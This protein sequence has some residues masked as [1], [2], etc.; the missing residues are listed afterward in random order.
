MKVLYAAS[1]ARPFVASGGLADV[2]GSLPQS[3]VRKGVDCR[4]VIPLYS[5]ISDELRANI[6]FVME[7]EIYVAW[8][9]R[10][11][12]VYESVYN[13]VTYY[14]IEN[15]YYFARDTL[16]EEFD[17]AERF[18][19]FCRAVLE[20]LPRIDFKP[21]VINANDWQAAL[22]P[23]YQNIYYSKNEWYSHI[24]TII[25]IHNIAF[26]GIYGFDI[27]SDILGLPDWAVD[28]I[29]FNNNINFLKGSMQ[30]ADTIITVS[31]T[32]AKEIAGQ[33]VDNTGYDF[34]QGLTP[35]LNQEMWKL[36]GII[37]GVDMDAINPSKDK[38]LYAKYRATTFQRGK[39]INKLKLQERLGLNVSADVPM[40]SMVTRIDAMQKGCQLVLDVMNSGLLDSHDFQF[41]LLGSAADGDGEG[42]YMEEAFRQ[43]ES[44][45]KG[46]V[47]AYI[48]FVPELAQ[49]IY[50]ASDIYLMPSKYEPCGL[51]QIIA[52][53][54]GAIPVVRET[55]G[56]AD[57][58]TDSLDGLGNGFTFRGYNA[59]DFHNA[60]ERA[61]Q[62]YQ[63]RK[64]WNLLT[65]RAMERDFSWDS[66]PADEYIKLYEGLIG[67][68]TAE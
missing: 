47:V 63:D 20:M 32:Y 18:A 58:I 9:S 13:G 7:F 39:K 12:V 29:E 66:G 3:L 2:A 52:L 21:D 5:I 43:L 57:T 48:G 68:T 17:N 65:Q 25:T 53:K 64:G 62:G 33:H 10:S 27:F 42:K 49:K 44:R 30:A 50:A 55:G 61:L 22:I 54:Y 11:C 24:K 45:Y 19:F 23:V 36:S 51:S 59:D 67:E 34:G 46:R 40:I 37:N 26:Q 4:V 56:L 1:E 38:H 28:L 41:V 31:P 16:Y 6:K 14:F 15:D 35:F 60:I 8:R